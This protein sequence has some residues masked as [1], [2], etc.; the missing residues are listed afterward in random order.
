M[1]TITLALL[2]C[3]AFA[4]PALAMQ[5]PTPSKQ[6]SRIRTA[7]YSPSNVIHLT[8]TDLQPLQI[9]LEDGEAVAS[10]AGIGVQTATKPEDIK[11]IRDWF[12]RW[13]GNAIVL[14]PLRAERASMLFVDTRAPDGTMRH[15]RFQLDTRNT[16]DNGSDTKSAAST[17]AFQV[18][19]DGQDPDAYDAVNMTYPEVIAA[20]RRAVWEAGA[21]GREKRA[22]AKARKKADA[23]AEWRLREARLPYAN[24]RN[25]RYEA[26]N[27]DASDNSCGVIGPERAAGISDDGIE[28]R[29]LFAPDVA[30]PAPYV[31]DQDGHESV[32]QHSQVETAD[33][34]VMTLHTVAPR[35]IL[36]RG[37]RVCALTNLA[38]DPI[39]HNTGTNTI[40]ADVVR[41]VR[42]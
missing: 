30:L 12:I 14:Q 39:G 22:A 32:V 10:F 40:S 26:Q 29:L 8:S 15:Y 3:A 34:L 20:Q 4:A 35:V 41:E 9:V 31:L 1:K 5:E 11:S 28:T 6:D 16:T 24:G 13:S 21:A 27:I 18:V 25:W 33:G 19:A 23:T 37:E 2:A 36:R 7:T 17:V 42:Q 38:Y